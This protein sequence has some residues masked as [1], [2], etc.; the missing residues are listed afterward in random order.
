MEMEEFTDAV[1][2]V[3]SIGADIRTLE[4]ESMDVMRSRKMGDH[5]D[6]EEEGQMSKEGKA[7]MP[8]KPRRLLMREASYQNSNSVPPY[9]L[10]SN[11][12]CSSKVR[13][14]THNDVE[15]QS[16]DYAEEI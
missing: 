4:T 8:V 1:E 9:L 14:Q 2:K 7:Q 16:Q 10:M 12:N 11:Q 15:P 6:G 5:T 13:E 3:R